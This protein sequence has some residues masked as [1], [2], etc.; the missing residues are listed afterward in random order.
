MSSAPRPQPEFFFERSLGKL[1]AG[2]LRSEGWTVHLI[3]EHFEHNGEHTPDEEWIEFGCSR[4][5]ICLTKDKKIRYRAHEIGAL[6]G[7]HIFCLT[8]GNL[9]VR[10]MA[11]RFVAA[12]LSITRAAAK[13]DV[14]FWHV[15]RDGAVKRMWP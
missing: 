2:I 10:E 5:W 15:Y 1:T 7:G 14:G 3:H 8:D 6:S 12:R 9:D 4:G 11:A 13:H